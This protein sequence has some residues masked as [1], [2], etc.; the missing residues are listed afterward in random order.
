[1]GGKKARTYI[2]AHRIIDNEKVVSGEVGVHMKRV[3]QKPMNAL[4][5]ESERRNLFIGI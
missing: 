4:K 5:H 3:H 2:V 1:M